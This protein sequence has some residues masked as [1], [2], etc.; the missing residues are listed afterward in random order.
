MTNKSSQ[1]HL[2]H[3]FLDEAGD[4]TFYGKGRLPI[5]GAN[6][7]S[8]AFML[9]MVKF[10]TELAPIRQAVIA[11]QKQVENEPYFKHI[12]SIQ[13]RKQKAVFIFMR[14]TIYQK[15]AKYFTTI[16]VRWI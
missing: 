6:G 13:D 15:S 5:V 16:S 12:P 3:R 8:L 11:L 1:L 9:G 7:V 2:Y 14:Q 10:K 4:T